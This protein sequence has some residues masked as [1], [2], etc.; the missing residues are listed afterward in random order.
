MQHLIT[1]WALSL[2]PVEH[3]MGKAWHWRV[4]K[5][6]FTIAAQNKFYVFYIIRTKAVQARPTKNIRYSVPY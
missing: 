4:S 6:L 3:F 2:N 5:P 1:K